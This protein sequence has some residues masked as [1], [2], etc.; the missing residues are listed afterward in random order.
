MQGVNATC[1]II[2]VRRV[3]EWRQRNKQLSV[4]GIDG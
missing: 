3:V 1:E 2:E 4:D